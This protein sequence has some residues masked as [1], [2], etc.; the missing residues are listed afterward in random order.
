MKKLSPS[1]AV[2]AGYDANTDTYLKFITNSRQ[3]E[4]MEYLDLFLNSLDK[5]S[6]VLDLGCGAGI[7]TTKKLAK[8]FR[9]LGVDISTEQIKLAKQNTPEAEYI[10]GN[11]LDINFEKD[12]FA[13]ILAFY[14]LF[15][16]PRDSHEE[17]FRRI[18]LWLKPGGVFLATFLAA[19][20]E[21][22]ELMDESMKKAPM[23]LSAASPEKTKSL[24]ENSG[25]EII[26]A[27]IS[28]DV[29]Q[30]GSEDSFFWVFA[31]KTR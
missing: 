4:Q 9:V 5:D 13:G 1:E 12:K 10:A 25:F 21:S 3:R 15:H 24:I 17:L 6:Q 28:T 8:K 18:Y 11:I 2:K 14:S 30:D 27:E 23:F 26:R 19:E 22:L 29:E 7:P 31:C 16:I 20:H